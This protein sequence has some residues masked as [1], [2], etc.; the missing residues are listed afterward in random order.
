MLSSVPELLSHFT[1]NIQNL[2][3]KLFQRS[4]TQQGFRW[5]ISLYSYSKID[6]S[7]FYELSK[8][9]LRLQGFMVIE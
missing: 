7:L 6:F 1:F 3:V 2:T 5:Y 9:V 8:L 4:E